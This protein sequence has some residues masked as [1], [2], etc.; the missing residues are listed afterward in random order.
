[1]QFEYEDLLSKAREMQEKTDQIRMK[2]HTDVQTIRRLTIT[3]EQMEAQTGVAK[4]AQ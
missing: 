3:L 1:M 4:F 2:A